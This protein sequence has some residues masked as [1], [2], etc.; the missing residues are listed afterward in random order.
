MKKTALSLFVCIAMIL[1]LVACG[2][3]DTPVAATETSTQVEEPKPEAEVEAPKD[4]EKSE[5]KKTEEKKKEE[6][7]PAETPKPA[8]EPKV[9][10]KP[11]KKV[12]EKA[13]T[14]PKTEEVPK[15]EEAPKK[16]EPKPEE[17]KVEAKAE[18]EAAEDPAEQAQPQTE[19]AAPAP[20]VP[21]VGT[22]TDLNSYIA[23]GNFSDAVNYGKAMG[24]YTADIFISNIDFNW[25]NYFIE[26]STS[27]QETSQAY[28]AVGGWNGQKA[29][30][31]YA[32]V[33]DYGDALDMSNGTTVSKNAVML[34]PSVISYMKSN[35]DPYS[36]PQ[37][38]GMNGWITWAEL[39]G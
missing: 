39:V 3:S 31:T 18:P 33:V 13:E 32:Y 4:E 24:A 2:N 12:E 37:I 15:K 25:P 23:D 36:V 30:R 1:S 29:D 6:V 9:E 38:S 11:E 19:T 26:L 34:L 21:T 35:P 16:E 10:E 17:K 5:E 7:K 28:I 8:E 22:G 20:A 27:Y 14:T